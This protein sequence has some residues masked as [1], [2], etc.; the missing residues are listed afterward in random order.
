MIELVLDL[1]YSLHTLKILKE[2]FYCVHMYTCTFIHM[3]IV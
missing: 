3:Y 1:H 2:P